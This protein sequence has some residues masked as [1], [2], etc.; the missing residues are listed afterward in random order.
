MAVDMRASQ[1]TWVRWEMHN[2]TMDQ[3]REH[4]MECAR[5]IANESEYGY[6]SLEALKKEICYTM[7]WMEIYEGC[8]HAGRRIWRAGCKTNDP[9]VAK[10]IENMV[11]K[12]LIQISK[13]GKGYKVL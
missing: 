11:A 10:T 3:K 7:D 12:G 8:T 2:K 6:G 4:I 1:Y 9:K 13:S 5:E